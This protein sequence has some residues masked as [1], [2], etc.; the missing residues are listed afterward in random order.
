MVILFLALIG[1][2][3]LGLGFVGGVGG[4]LFY[5]LLTAMRG[6]RGP[7]MLSHS[8][9]ET[10]SANR[11]GILSLQSLCFRLLFAGTGPLIGMLADRG[12]V[13]HGFRILFY[14]FFVVLP[15]LAILFFKN[16]A[17]PHVGSSR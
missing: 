17:T 9:R 14:A 8:Q 2:G 16:I 5:Y 1:V 7:M 10:P 3:Y 6:L 4:F 12:G 11:A 13:Q 15:P